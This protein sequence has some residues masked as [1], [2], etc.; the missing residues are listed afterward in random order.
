MA[1]NPT[2]HPTPA[3]G[4]ELS[5][6]KR[7]EQ[8]L[9]AP[10]TRRDLEALLGSPQR[11]ARFIEATLVA[12][13]ANPDLFHATRR[14]LLIACRRAA[15]DGLAPD[16]KEAVFTVYNTK[17]KKRNDA[18]N[19][20][21]FYEQQ[22]QYNP[23]V[24]GI[25]KKMY[26]LVDEEGNRLVKGIQ[27]EV[28][29]AKDKF[30]VQ[31]GDEPRIDHVPHLKADRGDITAAY[32]IVTMANGEKVREVVMREDIDKIR[33]QS[34]APDSLMWKT[35]F[36][37]GAIKVAIKRAAKAMPNSADLDRVIAHDN[38]ATG[39]VNDG[40]ASGDL[41]DIMGDPSEGSSPALEDQRADQ[42]AR[43]VPQQTTAKADPALERAKAN[44]SKKVEPKQQ[45][46][47]PDPRPEPPLEGDLLK[48]GEPM[49]KPED[50]ER[51]LRSQ[52]TVD[53]LDLVADEIRSAGFADAVAA[54]LWK[55][56][57]DCKAALIAKATGGTGE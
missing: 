12:L 34:K 24:A 7:F 22:V 20:V 10:Q 4:G 57:S 52:T 41:T 47:D 43:T 50:L 9:Q 23:M 3:P 42:A 55:L 54:P 40:Q 49:F 26:A 48:A 11:V 53:A 25:V 33:Q 51:D 45:Q 19:L 5:P 18:G 1:S 27:R 39:I 29:Y 44:R 37:Q 15:M 46:T 8:Y 31:K 6:Y 28:V 30:H 35:F 16:G 17:V 13:Q 2:P 36:D 21:E 14:S 38:E 56:Y 32:V